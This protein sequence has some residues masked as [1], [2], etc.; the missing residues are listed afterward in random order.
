MPGLRN[1][2]PLACLCPD[3]GQHLN[4]SLNIQMNILFDND[5]ASASGESAFINRLSSETENY[6]DYKPRMTSFYILTVGV[7]DY[8]CT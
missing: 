4:E 2:F 8:N 3:N 1:A 6:K 5:V 7:E